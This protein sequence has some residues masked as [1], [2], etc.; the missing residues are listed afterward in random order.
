RDE[1]RVRGSRGGERALRRRERGDLL[2]RLRLEPAVRLL[3]RRHLVRAL[4][5][6]RLA[7]D[8][9][10]R[11]RLV[12]RVCLVAGVLQRVVALDEGVA[13]APELRVLLRQLVTL[14]HEQR[15]LLPHERQ[16]RRGF[17]LRG[18][19]RQLLVEQRDLVADRVAPADVCCDR[20]RLRG[21]RLRG[22]RLGDRRLG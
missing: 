13:R 21:R 3:E 4:A 5:V 16:P 10:L 7:R 12:L 9:F 19:R 18:E 1:V 8:L 17:T 20:K 15:V 11:Q 22:R 14:L 2:R 6:A